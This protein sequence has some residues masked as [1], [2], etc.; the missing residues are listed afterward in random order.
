MMRIL[1]GMMLILCLGGGALAADAVKDEPVECYTDPLNCLQGELDTL[2]FEAEGTVCNSILSM[3]TWFTGETTEKEAMVEL[4]VPIPK[5]AGQYIKVAC[6]REI[7]GGVGQTVLVVKAGCREY[8]ILTEN[9]DAVLPLPGD[10]LVSGGF[11]FEISVLVREGSEFP[12]VEVAPARIREHP[13]HIELNG[14]T[15]T[16]GLR[17]VFYSFPTSFVHTSG[18]DMSIRL[19]PGSGSWS[20]ANF[21]NVQAVGD[22]LEAEATALSLMAPFEVA[23]P[24]ITLSPAPRQ[25]LLMGSVEAGQFVNSVVQV[26]NTGTGVLTGA[27]SVVDPLGNFS[28][29]GTASYSLI[30]NESAFVTVRYAPAGA[31]E[32]TAALVFTG[33]GIESVTL[34]LQGTGID[35][36]KAETAAG[37]GPGASSKGHFSDFLVVLFT[38][39]LLG[40]ACLSGTPKRN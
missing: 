27:A 19:E 26:T 16:D 39:V 38:G 14:L 29:S 28:V 10:A 24:V 20:R 40:F 7:M 37:C 15:F 30:A 9:P 22:A 32:H 36:P 11:F 5:H 33:A 3:I 23:E 1:L 13:V 21:K 17:P 18:A 25:G 34:D 35:T 12:F 6:P 4:S 8:Q 2:T 31:G